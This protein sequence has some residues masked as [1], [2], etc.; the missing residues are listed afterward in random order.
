MHI[1]NTVAFVTGANRGI[2]RALA[3][4]LLERGARRVYAAA[5]VPA[6]LEGLTALDPARVAPVRLDITDRQQVAAAAALA[7]DVAL[8]VNNAG[9]ITFGSVLDAPQELVA[10]DL[11]TNYYGTLAM[12]RAFAPLIEANGGGGIVNLLTLV[13]LASMPG[14]GAY[15]ASKAAAWS[16]TQSIRADLARKGVAVYGV[17]PGAVDTEMIRAMEMPKADPRDVA[18]AILDGVEADTE[19][20][21]PEPMS[22]QVYE[23]WRQD[24]KAVERQF[25]AL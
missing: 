7:G 24:H 12:V 4:H 18:R 6:T 5:R 21:F 22:R 20:I 23:G 2:G 19:D 14:L 3:E 15:N 16:M 8:L 1:E 9:A 10:R 11:E 13:A 17:F 25:A